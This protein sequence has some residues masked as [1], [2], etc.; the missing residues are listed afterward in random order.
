MKKII[1]IL[2][3]LSI[4]GCSGKG[5]KYLDCNCVKSHDEE[6]AALMFV[7]NDIYPTTEIKTIC[8]LER[9]DS[10]FIDSTGHRTIINHKWQKTSEGFTTSHHQK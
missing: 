7:G 8:D 1:I 6:Y 9:C 2:I 4:T 10:V 5:F 3:T